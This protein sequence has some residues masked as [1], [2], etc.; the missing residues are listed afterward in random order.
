MTLAVTRAM[1]GAEILKLR[2]SRGIMAF[3]LALSVGVV[4]LLFAWT[5]I[6]HASNPQ[7]YPPAGGLHG[8]GRAVQSL[9]FYFGMLAAV[10]IGA[11]AGTMDRATGVFRDLAVT[12]RS[13][14]ALFAVRVPGAIAVTLALNLA[15]YAIALIGTYALAGGSATPDAGLVLQG[16]GW[17][18]LANA[19]VATLAV[20]VGSLT[21]SRAVSITALIGWEA[22]VTNL[23][24]NASSLGAA[25]E[26]L[27]NA[28][29]N[30]VMP[31]KGDRPMVSESLATTVIVLLAWAVVP[32]VLGAW[33]TRRQDA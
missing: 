8:F 31:V 15:A 14:L 7:Q 9:G 2:R 21:G 10:L 22:I 27:L 33:R 12:G 32:T 17:I 16:A 5:G 4:V 24:L 28:A 13:R 26:G 20:G 1:I 18:V 6:Q 25:R 23:L 30:Q 11:E 29:L 19:V 3:A